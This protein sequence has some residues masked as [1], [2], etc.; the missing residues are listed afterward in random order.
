MLCYFVARIELN[1]SRSRF[2]AVDRIASFGEVADFEAQA[3]RRLAVPDHAAATT[4]VR[5]V[6]HIETSMRSAQS[7]L[8]DALGRVGVFSSLTREQLTLLL[9]AMVPAPFEAGDVVFEQGDEGDLFYVVLEGRAVA[10]RW[11]PSDTGEGLRPAAS[12]GAE[13][14]EDDDSAVFSRPRSRSKRPALPMPGLRLNRSKEPEVICLC[15]IEAGGFF[16]ER[17][18]LRAEFRYAT[19][20]ALTRMSTMCITREGFEAVLGPLQALVGREYG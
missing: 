20:K 2:G 12:T 18:I 7:R 19:I 9:G 3:G 10:L 5:S 11:E 6:E 15:E 1:T 16:G 4:L 8:L 14:D 13:F 17:A